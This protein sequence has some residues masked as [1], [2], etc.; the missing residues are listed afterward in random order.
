VR[1]EWLILADAAQIV[2][3]KLYLMGGG[4]DTLTVNQPLP[5]T[6]RC[7][8]AAAYSVPWTETNQRFNAEIAIVTE[9]GRETGRIAAQIEVGRPA[10]SPPGSDQRAQIAAEMDL[11]FEAAGSYAIISSIDGREDLRTSFR[12]VYAPG[13]SQAPPA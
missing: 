12:V 5:A 13:L 8:V 4:W 3:G 11:R 1:T 7:A 2:A 9:D 6:R 10:G